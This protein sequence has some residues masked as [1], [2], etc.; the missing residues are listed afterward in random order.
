[1]QRSRSK[2]ASAFNFI[3]ASIN[4]SFS[5]HHAVNYPN[6]LPWSIAIH[7][8]CN[9]LVFV[10]PRIYEFASTEMVYL[11]QFSSSGDLPGDHNWNDL[12]Q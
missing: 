8:L 5:E 6:S 4:W 2:L 1:M 3:E 7:W 10:D 12:G 11:L 9:L